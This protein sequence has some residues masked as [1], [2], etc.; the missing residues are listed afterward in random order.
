M[1]SNKVKRLLEAYNEAIDDTGTDEK[2]TITKEEYEKEVKRIM[3]NDFRAIEVKL[4]E[5]TKKFKEANDG[6]NSYD[7]P[8]ADRA[9]DYM[10]FATATLKDILDDKQGL[11]VRGSLYSKIRKALGYNA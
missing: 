3:E 6:Y 9:L 4:F 10:A 8:M 11:N 7:L 1:A 5:L 2:E